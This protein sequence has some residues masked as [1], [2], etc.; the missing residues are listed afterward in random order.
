MYTLGVKI[1]MSTKRP[2]HFDHLLQVLK[3]SPWSLI[4][5]IFFNVFMHVYS[6]RPW[7]DNPL[8]TKFWHHQKAQITLTIC[9]KFT[10]GLWILILYTFFKLFYTCIKPRGKGRQTPGVKIL[11]S[12]ESPYHFDH[13]L[14]VSKI[15]LWILILY[16]FL[17]AFSHVY[18]TGAG[19]DNPLWTKFCCQ[20]KGSVTLP[21]CC[22]FQKISL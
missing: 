10:N 22:K 9:C 18:S 6:P 3:K 5:Y 15:S 21:I 19:A 12:T 20:Q 17:N 16:T 7:A 4:L 13:L 2:Y 14:Q 11:T 8:V 1:L